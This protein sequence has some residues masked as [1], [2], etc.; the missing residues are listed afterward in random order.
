[1]DIQKER[2]AFEAWFIENGILIDTDFNV[3]KRAF[4]AGAAWRASKAK[5]K[6][7]P[8]GFVLVSI[9]DL[10]RAAQNIRELNSGE[11]YSEEIE[12]NVC[13]IETMIEAQES[14]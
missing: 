11:Y 6:A 1:M 9:D 4:E 2:E 8:D 12:E 14:K 5:A 3:A 7:V 10:A 13:A